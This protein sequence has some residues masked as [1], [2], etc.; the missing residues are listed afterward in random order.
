MK[1]F[2]CIAILSLLALSP[3]LSAADTGSPI[4]DNSRHY[5][6]VEGLSSNHIYGIVQDSLG[7]IW[8]GTRN[9]L[10]RYDG[11][12]FR[13]YI[14]SEQNP[15]SISSNDIRRLMIDRRGEIWISL[16][17]GVDIYSPSSD[18]FRHFDLTT[19]E[20]TGIAGQVIEII[21]DRDGEIW[22]STISG[23]FRYT[24]GTELL[25]A[26]LH[27]PEDP[28]S[29]SENYISTVFESNDGTIWV[30][31]YNTGLCSFS[32]SSGKFTRYKK[33]TTRR[34]SLSDNSINTITE[35]S[36]GN[37]WL[38]TVHSGI[39]RFNRTS[40]VFTNF[41]ARKDNSLLHMH[42]ITEI[43]TG[44]LLVCSDKGAFVYSISE[45]GL[46]P[47][48]GKTGG[49]FS[50]SVSK[51]IYSALKDRDGN[52]WLGSLYDGVEFHPSYNNFVCYDTRI[53][54][55]STQGK[56]VTSIVETGPDSYLIGTTDTGIMH[57][58]GHSGRITPWRTTRQ[59]NAPSYY[60]QS[61]VVDGQTLWVAS[62]Q[63]GVEAIDLR[64]R[65]VRSY[66]SDSREPHSRASVVYCSSMGR[67]WVGTSAGLFYY[68]RTHDRFIGHGPTSQIASITEGSGG[69]L[70]I[71]TAHDGLYS[72]DSK[73]DSFRHYTYDK[74][75][76]TTITRNTL[77]VLATDDSGRLWIGT[78][79]YGICRYDEQSDSF[80]RYDSLNLPNNII[81]HIIP[82]GN[83]L[84][85][86][87]DK[88]LAL[89]Y[90]D[91]NNPVCYSRFDGIHNDMFSIGSGIKAS[92]DR[93]L[94]GSSDGLCIFTPA[95]LSKQ[96]HVYPA[97]ITD[98]FTNNQRISLRRGGDF[99][100][101]HKEQN[102]LTLN[103][104]QSSI[105]I[106]F[107]SPSYHAPENLRYRY[108]LDDT[109]AHWHIADLENP[110]AHYT[111]LKP[112]EY[113]FCV[114]AGNINCQW[115]QEETVLTIAVRPP[116]LQ[117]TTAYIL[118][119]IIAVIAIAMIARLLLYRSEKRYQERIAA[120]EHE[121]ERML[122]NRQLN[123]FT[124]IAHEIRTP[125]SLIIGPLE[126][127]TKNKDIAERYSDYISVIE[128]NYQR[129]YSLVNQLLNFRRM[130]SEHYRLCYDKHN[131]GD[132]VREVVSMFL[133]TAQQRDINVIVN[134]ADGETM[135]LVDKEAVTKI[136]SNLLSNAIKF[137]DNEIIVTLTASAEGARISVADNGPGVPVEERDKIFHPFYQM[138]TNSSGHGGVGIGLNICNTYIKMMGGSISCSD[139][140]DGGAGAFI[141]VHIPNI[142]ETAANAKSPSAKGS[143]G[144]VVTEA[145]KAAYTLLLVDDN[146]EMLQFLAKIF[147]DSYCV[148]TSTNG[149]QAL[150]ILQDK[151]IDLVVSD[152]VMDGISGMELC[153]RIKS[154]RTTD[155]IPVIMLTAKTDI[156]TKIEGLEQG[157]D[158]YI[159]KPF[160]PNY[161]Q[162]QVANILHKREEIRTRYAQNPITDLQPFTSN[163]RDDDFLRQCHDVIVAHMSD[164]GLSVDFLARE[165][166]MSRSLIFKKL[167]AVTGMTPNDFMKVI[168]LKEASRLMVEGRY[169]ITEIGFL[170]GF[171][172]SSYFA[173][174]FAKQFGI[175][176]TEFMKR[177][178]EEK[179]SN[180]T[181]IL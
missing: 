98:L 83:R 72:Y 164:S 44:E 146:P 70:W 35:D 31:T 4:Y 124:N 45:S 12:N 156:N 161:L 17:N 82:D 78:N 14:H 144:T 36:Y 113:R 163:S 51:F 102:R 42:H 64:T 52:I 29:I 95:N 117:T 162:A 135:A 66:L 94:L 123:F 122:Y 172:S 150:E 166:A 49:K 167:K 53:N 101:Q 93:I 46:Q 63:R 56:V 5:T 133:P 165:M 126:Y 77:N 168:R 125:L 90:P 55:Q 48:N 74:N 152:I 10:C 33:S 15:N 130:D 178:E 27:D 180:N 96:S 60:V 127:I 140:P 76:P 32:K 170:A 148:I 92:N 159:E 181:N 8:F 145:E 25:K 7:F 153:R 114:Q 13:N 115:N 149:E 59:I 21:E 30:G 19:A 169:R 24:P 91:S 87:T 43:A 176:P 86:A 20:G 80:V 108:R 171:N 132:I 104:K 105:S 22:I 26:Y 3:T 160:S 1:R 97:I 136:L 141:S 103:H 151:D 71:A 79:S 39:D 107:S 37:L 129:L 112:G 73:S 158:A 119:G 75:D 40:G 137:T 11:R 118:Y 67:I 120:I 50:R 138:P 23:L 62:Y 89:F 58:D 128:Q 173:K 147:D 68:D 57:L 154:E 99:R 34:N 155:H 61:M 177:L 9:G 111:G 142:A 175:L 18:S 157:V 174:C 41:P 28:D 88:G 110:S 2:L 116:L 6:V 16:D 85:I 38:G 179:R 54:C 69:R 47:A 65:A 134:I 84:W 100:Q 143:G 139:R 109:D 106:H 131:L 121:N 81:S